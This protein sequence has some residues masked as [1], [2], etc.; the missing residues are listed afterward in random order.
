M[1]NDTTPIAIN[2]SQVDRTLAMLRAAKVEHSV[3][4]RGKPTTLYRFFD[5][6]GKLL[7][8]GITEVGA[9]R[10]GGHRGTKHW[11][12]EVA[13]ITT[14]HFECRDDALD[15]EADAI[16]AE[17]PQYNVVHNG[18]QP[19]QPRIPRKVRKRPDAP[20]DRPRPRDYLMAPG[21]WKF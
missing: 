2:R 5:A 20:T 9:M 17:S 8:I 6:D 10:F 15:A 4:D 12:W 1:N 11:W 21:F 3:P 14:E 16:R 18:P 7:Y 13:N 19:A